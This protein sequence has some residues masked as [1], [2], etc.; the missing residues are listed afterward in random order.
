[1]TNGRLCGRI[2]SVPKPL[3]LPMRS[4]STSAAT[5]ALMW[6]TVP[7]AKSI[8]ATVAAPSVT[9]NTFAAR[10]FSL[11]ERK[12]PPHTMWASGKYVTVT[13]IAVNV[14]HVPNLTRSA[15]APEMS[16]TVMIANVTW[17]AMSTTFG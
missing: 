14:S 2:G 17:N 8:G 5:P 1:M 11:A 15:S 13:Q 6:T 12:P 10:P 4:A 9:P 3:R 7:P 16:A